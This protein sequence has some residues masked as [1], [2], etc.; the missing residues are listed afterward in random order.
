MHDPFGTQQAPVQSVQVLPA[1]RN[2]LGG[3]SSMDTLSVQE[4]SPQQAPTVWADAR[5]VPKVSA[6][7]DINTVRWKG[8]LRGRM[9]NL[10]TRASFTA[11][12]KRE[13][14][15]KRQQHK[16]SRGAAGSNDDELC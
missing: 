10:L 1:P 11:A 7:P 6:I 12:L 9:A 15:G 5:G 4:K 14:P 8:W 16:H 3:Q 13:K 2:S